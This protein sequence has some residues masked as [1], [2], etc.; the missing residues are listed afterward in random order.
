[1]FLLNIARSGKVTTFLNKNYGKIAHMLRV[2]AISGYFNAGC[3]DAGITIQ[4]S[5]SI[6]ASVNLIRGEP[7]WI[8]LVTQVMAVNW[9]LL[10]FHNPLDEFHE[11]K[12]NIYNRFNLYLSWV[13]Q[14][15]P[16]TK[17]IL[18]F[19]L[20]LIIVLPSIGL[21]YYY[22]PT[23]VSPNSSFIANDLAY[24]KTKGFGPYLYQDFRVGNSTGDSRLVVTQLEFAGYGN[25]HSMIHNSTFTFNSSNPS[26]EL[27]ENFFLFLI[28]NNSHPL[29]MK[30]LSVT[31]ENRSISYTAPVLQVSKY[32]SQGNTGISFNW[33]FPQ[34][35]SVNPQFTYTMAIKVQ[36]YSFFGPLYFSMGTY[37]LHASQF[38]IIIKYN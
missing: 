24:S 35:Y 32:V 6:K 1:M 9:R 25:N 8:N 22:G 26:L 31:L 18:A 12:N 3:L 28:S 15:K 13:N 38:P 19:A 10:I 23:E 37:T 36:L 29:G 11:N 21:I 34:R 14:M 20:I 30:I 33:L 27:G 7:T 5:G 4:F 2:Y 16:K 17:I